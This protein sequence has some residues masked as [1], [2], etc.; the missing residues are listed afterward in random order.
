M[1]QH[2]NKGLPQADFSSFH[3][4]EKLKLGEIF[5]SGLSEDTLP[6]TLKIFDTKILLYS[7]SEECNIN[8]LNEI[9]CRYIIIK[10][11]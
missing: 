9:A 6:F 5:V 2:P 7:T 3:K 4:V 10:Q 8:I 11:K 1:Q